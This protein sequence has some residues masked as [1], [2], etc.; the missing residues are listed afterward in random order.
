MDEAS[1]FPVSRRDPGQGRLE[2]QWSPACSPT[3]LMPS[4]GVGAQASHGKFSAETP[5]TG[6][7]LL[8]A[9]AGARM[10]VPPIRFPP[11]PGGC[12]FAEDP[13][14]DCT[15]VMP[16]WSAQADPRV[17]RA[18]IVPLARGEGRGFDANAVN[19]RCLMGPD[20]E[21]IAFDCRGD[22]ARIDLV[23]G[24]TGPGPATFHFE[25]VAD[26]RLAS[27]IQALDH[28]FSPRHRAKPAGRLHR[29]HLALL[30]RD[31]RGDGASW[32]EIA[33]LLL[34]PGEWPGAGEYRKS[35][36]RR[37]VATGL[38]LCRAGPQAVLRGT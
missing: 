31:A 38:S 33:H 16:V 34:G 29:Q 19:A 18:R 10:P 8:L 13:S 17:L 6:R 1:G 4:H 21:Y 28:I 25:I 32:R 36:V 20:G 3:A 14:H 12:T 7:G 5:S 26:G 23:A 37:L 24:R 9:I 35:A 22:V 2:S 11:P 27:Q 30:A 15:C